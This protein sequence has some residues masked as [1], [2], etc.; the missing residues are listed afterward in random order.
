MFLFPWDVEE[1][2]KALRPRTYVGFL[3]PSIANFLFSSKICLWIN[4]TDSVW[5]LSETKC[6]RH[7]SRTHFS[8]CLHLPPQEIFHSDSSSLHEFSTESLYPGWANCFCFSGYHIICP[9]P[10]PSSNAFHT[11][12]CESHQVYLIASLLFWGDFCDVNPLVSLWPNI[13]SYYHINWHL[14]VYH[15]AM[16]SKYSLPMCALYSWL[17]CKKMLCTL[18]ARLNTECRIKSRCFHREEYIHWGALKRDLVGS[19][20][21]L[22]WFSYRKCLK[23][24]GH[25]SRKRLR[26]IGV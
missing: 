15:L 13:Y 21:S 23:S 17:F 24:L 14:I 9:P 20:G 16:L 26:L 6:V 3:T 25:L 10:I 7:L 2:S 12:L 18:V 5:G 4:L 1:R 22:K 19:W 8:S 11:L